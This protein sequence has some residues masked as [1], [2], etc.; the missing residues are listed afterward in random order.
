VYKFI[1]HYLPK[2][3]G[4]QAISTALVVA[5]P[6]AYDVKAWVRSNLG[7]V[8]DLRVTEDKTP[9]NV[10]AEPLAKTAI[11]LAQEHGRSLLEQGR[12]EGRDEAVKVITEVLTTY[13]GKLAVNQIAVSIRRALEGLG[14]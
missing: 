9:A 10:T 7:E 6:S 1:V 3:M 8:Q 12:R 13:R 2:D 11:Q 4:D 5:G 14:K